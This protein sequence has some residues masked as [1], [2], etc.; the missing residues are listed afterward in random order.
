MDRAL[1]AS[2]ESATECLE[3]ETMTQ[4]NS[5]SIRHF[6]DV[7]TNDE[8]QYVI[9]KTFGGQWTFN[10]RSGEAGL[11][12]WS[13]DLRNDPFFTG[14]FFERVR[15]I[16]QINLTLQHVYANGQTY[17]QPGSFHTDHDSDDA[18]TFL[19]YANPEWDLSWG[20]CTVFE[21]GEQ[22]LPIPNSGILFP[23]KI[24]HLGAEPTRHFTGLRATVAF[25]TRV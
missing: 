14:R 10:G 13:M 19:Y 9:K 15:A 25:K 4:P 5:S 1:A 24:H 22:V 23:A 12:F 8:Q 2:A 18:Y 17:G 21:S 3:A 6:H 20:G 7:L 11:V 16:T